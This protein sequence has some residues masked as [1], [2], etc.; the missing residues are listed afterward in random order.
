MRFVCGNLA[1]PRDSRKEG[2]QERKGESWL[3]VISR[4][5]WL[6]IVWSVRGLVK[7]RGGLEEG[8]T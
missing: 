7:S 1:F 4:V 8:D 3:V 6:L 5:G 2:G